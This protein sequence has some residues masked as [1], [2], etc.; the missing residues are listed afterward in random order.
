MIAG[1]LA[2][3]SMAMPALAREYGGAA[4]VP[5]GPGLA[6]EPYFGTEPGRFLTPAETQALDALTERLIPGDESGPGARDAGV[7]LFIDQQLAGF[8]GR[9]QRW[10]MRGPFPEPLETQGYQSEHPP[11]RLVRE[12]LVAL[13]AYARATYDGRIFAELPAEDQDAILKGI[14]A[15]E[16]SFA[17]VSGSQFFSIVKELTIEGFFCDPIYGGNR[18]LVAWRYVGF[19]GARYDYRD[20]TGH[21]GRALNLPPVGLMGRPEWSAP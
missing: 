17:S 5:W 14:E 10:Y 1:L 12:G 19:P 21:G 2:G 6:N 7:V 13:D 16:I 11:A 9:G 18:D 4:G 8:Y 15:E 20:F 3:T